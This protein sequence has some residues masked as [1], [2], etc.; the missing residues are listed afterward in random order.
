MRTRAL[1]LFHNNCHKLSHGFYTKLHLTM[2]KKKLSGSKRQPTTPA[3]CPA[4]IS[5]SRS[6]TI[7]ASSLFILCF[8]MRW[9]IASGAGFD[10]NPSS[11][12]MKSAKGHPD[13]ICLDSQLQHDLCVCINSSFRL[14][15]LFLLIPHLRMDMVLLE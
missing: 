15:Q 8:F 7:I 14:I 5:I 12:V 11:L 6:P 13:G 9:L 1:S 4:R 2:R 10:K 3:L